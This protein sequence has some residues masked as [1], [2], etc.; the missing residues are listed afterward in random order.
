MHLTQLQFIIVEVKG[1]YIY[2]LFRHLKE[3]AFCEKRANDS[4]DKLLVFI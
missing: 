2:E 4:Y 1:K 3:P